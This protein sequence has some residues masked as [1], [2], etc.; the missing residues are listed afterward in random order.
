DDTPDLRDLLTMALERTGEF[1]VVAHAENGSQAIDLALA[2]DPDL[3]LLDI[4]MPVMD[5]LEA[6]PQVREACPQAI[7]VMLSGLRASEMTAKA[8]AGGADGYIQKGQPL[9]RLLSQLRT[10]VA[11]VSSA[12]RAAD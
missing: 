5:G 6:L 7:V 4:A 1:R 11:K 2:H 10:L 3:V 12:R 8:L 9:G